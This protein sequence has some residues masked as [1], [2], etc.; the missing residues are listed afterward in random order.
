MSPLAQLLLRVMRGASYAAAG[1]M[2]LVIGI[3]I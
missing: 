1:F 2:V 3:E